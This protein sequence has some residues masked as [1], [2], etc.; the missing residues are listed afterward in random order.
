MSEDYRWGRPRARARAG[1]TTALICLLMPT[2]IGCSS[3]P[4]AEPE[5]IVIAGIPVLEGATS[6]AGTEL[7][8]GFVVPEGA[9]LVGPTFDRGVRLVIDDVEIE[10]EGW[11]AVLL[12][13]GDPVDV[14]EGLLAD[15]IAAGY[16]MRSAHCSEEDDRPARCTIGGSR[17]GEL[18]IHS[19]RIEL[20]V[21]LGPS[22]HVQIV[23]EVE[24]RAPWEGELA[25]AGDDDLVRTGPI[26]I[27]WS[28][29]SADAW[30]ALTRP[31]EEL[32]KVMRE[33]GLVVEERTFLAAPTVM[34]EDCIGMAAVMRSTDS[35]DATLERYREQLTRIGVDPARIREG[36]SPDGSTEIHLFGSTVDPVYQLTFADDPDGGSWI[37]VGSCLDT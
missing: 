1:C 16:P 12:V 28:Q 2:T 27:E 9:V 14:L 33:I 19:L 29:P 6:P 7:R 30:P 10:N 35:V 11:T 20:A 37:L 22:A 13:T 26:D 18:G 21:G 17:R 8:N 3:G 31:G 36:I 25:P 23:E 4:P 15:A 5:A 24:N 34:A 32:P